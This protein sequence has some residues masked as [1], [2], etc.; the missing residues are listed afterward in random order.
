MPA[1]VDV[2]RRHAAPV[3]TRSRADLALTSQN[4]EISAEAGVTASDATPVVSDPISYL[5]TN[6][7]LLSRE[8]K[9]VAMLPGCIRSGMMRGSL[10]LITQDSVDYPV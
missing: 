1:C 7:L 10:A 9:A 3:A 2:A 8:S 4:G 6:D 5:M